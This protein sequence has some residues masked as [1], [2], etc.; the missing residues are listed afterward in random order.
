[1]PEHDSIIG[2]NFDIAVIGGGVVGCAVARRFTLSG[3][4]VVLVEKAADILAG[5]SKGNSAI[6]HTGFDAP[7]DSL[8]LRCM[9]AGYVE[10][11]EIRERF[12]LPVV[13]TGAIVA[14]WDDAQLLQLDGIVAKAHKNGVSNVA[15]IGSA[16]ILVH[17]PEISTA[18]LGGVL[19]PGEYIIDP[20]STPLAFIHQAL[21]NGAQVLRGTELLS[22]HFDGEHWLLKTSKGELRAQTVINCAGLFGDIVD[23]R[24]TGETEFEIRPR[25]GQFVV[26]DKAAA[27]LLDTIILPV[28][29][30]RTKGIV[31]TPTIFGN[32]LV[33]PTAEEQLDRA[34]ATVEREALEQLIARAKEILPALAAVPVT[35]TYAGLRPATESKEYRIRYDTGR[36]LIVAG[37]IRS[38]GLTSALGVAQYVEEL[39]ES[40]NAPCAKL[41]DPVWPAVP[42]LAEH[43]DRDWTRPG[44]GQ[45]VCHCEL[46]TQREIEAA[47]SGALPARDLGGLKR[48]TRA[49]LGRCQG[50]Y[51]NAKLADMTRD[52]FSAP[53]DVAVCRD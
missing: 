49:G 46:V 9:Q 7:A 3:A 37:G 38:T 17:A 15:R 45:I 35:A 16:D 4:K 42:M 18:V 28:P 33:G 1:M 53:M 48:R 11:L 10:F 29:T 12:R 50:F 5:A 39:F 22:G 14:A 23:Q 13:K 19:V 27:K 20:W 34:K 43:E 44:Y 8:E 32:V 24:L 47:L 26:F 51:C 21:A 41:N 40:N 6:L 30:E 25:K 31:L 52:R 2:E 36:N